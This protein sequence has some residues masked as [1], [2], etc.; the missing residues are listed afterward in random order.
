SFLMCLYAV[1]LYMQKKAPDEVATIV[2]ENNDE[3]RRAI[4]DLHQTLRDPAYRDLLRAYNYDDF[5]PE[6]IVD[7]VHFTEKGRSSPLQIA[8]LIAFTVKRHLQKSSESDRFYLP[9][10]R[11]FVTLPKDEAE[12]INAAASEAE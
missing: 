1:E 6:H 10:Q 5:I 4:K 7:D 8:D 12:A 2:M 3:A 9:L 11:R